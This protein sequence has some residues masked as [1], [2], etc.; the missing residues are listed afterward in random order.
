MTE[1]WLREQEAAWV[2]APQEQ[3]VY[4]LCVNDLMLPNVNEWDKEKIVSLFPMHIAN[5]IIDIPLFG[6]NEQDKL[7]WVDDVHGHYKVKSGY[8][9]A[10]KS[11]GNMSGAIFQEDWNS[12]WRIK[13]PPK[14]KHLMW[15]ICKG[16]LPARVRLQEKCVP[17]S[18]NCPICDHNYEDDM[19]VLFNCVESL[20]AVQYAGL[21]H[22]VRTRI[23]RF[24]NAKDLLLDVCATENATTAGQFAVVVWMIWRNRNNSVWNNEKESGRGIGMKARQFWLEWNSVQQLQHNNGAAVQQNSQSSWQPPPPNWFKC[25]VDAGFHRAENKTSLGWC[26]RDQRGHVI[27]AGTSWNDGKYSIL[28]GEAVALL[29]ALREMEHRG[30]SQVIFETD[31][32]NVV[33]AIQHFR[34]G[35]SEFS[36]IISHINNVLLVHPNFMVKFSKRQANMVAHMLARVAISWPRR[37][38]VNTLPACIETLLNNEMH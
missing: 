15:R 4:D 11:T 26:L 31:S 27:V 36:S 16:C 35:N 34:G 22:V 14:S 18:I 6:V 13:A 37:C 25:N 3:G 23:Q 38:I 2:P 12:L 7:I 8:N 28:E 5:S 1:P 19:H 10:L 29:H 30:F 17:C 21:E 9:L 20:Q 32:K 24:N 33:D